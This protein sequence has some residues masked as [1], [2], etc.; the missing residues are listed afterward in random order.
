MDP[1]NVFATE[2]VLEIFS[3][4][5]RRDLKAV[6][7]VC[8]RYE[9]LASPYLFTKA[10]IAARRG[11]M[12]VF[13]QITSHP[14]LSNYIRE[15]VYDASWFE[16][17][18]AASL[19]NF[20]QTSISRGV[21]YS[22]PPTSDVVSRDYETYVRLFKEQ[23]RILSDELPVALD[24]AFKVPRNIQRVTFADFSRN[25]YILGDRAEDFGNVFH[26]RCDSD[27]WIHQM[28]DTTNLQRLP[29]KF[30]AFKLLM[31]ALSAS[32]SL[33]SVQCFALGDGV[34]SSEDSCSSGIPH[35]FFSS[36]CA[37]LPRGVFDHHHLRHLRKLDLSI[38]SMG[39]TANEDKNVEVDTL[40]ELLNNADCLEEL[41]LIVSDC[42][43]HPEMPHK[44]ASLSRA[45]FFRSKTWKNLRTLELRH[46]E[47][48][49]SKLLEF[50]RRHRH[51]LRNIDIFDLVLLDSENWLSFCES[52]HVEY[53]NLHIAADSFNKSC[54][55]V[56]LGTTDAPEDQAVPINWAKLE[57]VA[58]SEDY[59]S[60]VDWI[61]GDESG[62]YSDNESF[63]DNVSTTSEELEFSAGSDDDSD[64]DSLLGLPSIRTLTLIDQG[65][66]KEAKEML[67]QNVEYR[68]LTLGEEHKDTLTDKENLARAYWHLHQLNKAQ[69]LQMH[70]L[71]KREKILGAEHPDT[72][73]SMSRLAA[74]YCDLNRLNQA[75]ELYMQALERRKKV[76]GAEHP[77]T[78]LSMINLAMTY[79]KMNRLIEAEELLVQVLEKH[80]EVLGPEHPCTLWSMVNLALTWKVQDY[81]GKAIS[82]MS[83]AVRLSETVLGGDHPDF[84]DHQRM[85][86]RWMEESSQEVW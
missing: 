24:I 42:P 43:S 57:R 20:A 85:L 72:L 17:S 19:K 11:V 3:N 48:E 77:D 28:P 70:V 52:V 63:T 46:F 35:T 75:E 13:R 6:R 66:Y 31:N 54:R 74:T 27:S 33:E 8:K 36:I 25:V 22:F 7:L 86:N 37:E 81:L 30:G 45:L 82:L 56:I 1:M 41:R 73:F 50:L 38:L 84:K 16:P 40:K 58:A 55:L 78:L 18:V 83:D 9:I 44:F 12:D 32:A 65:K 29:R 2:T 10:Y 64:L 23:E 49:S 4:F 53:P 15:I 61:F 69:E 62:S 79:V 14:V 76:L 5:E 67:E 21:R 34:S 80:K 26:S 51:C 47:L 68:S 71:E 60:D 39:T 59:D